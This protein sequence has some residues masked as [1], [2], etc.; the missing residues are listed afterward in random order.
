MSFVVQDLKK[1]LLIAKEEI[2]Y[3]YSSL[4]EVGGCPIILLISVTPFYTAHNSL[5]HAFIY[6]ISLGSFSPP[7]NCELM[8]L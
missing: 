4:E 6:I 8:K 3:W 1:R 7:N 2:M 5:K